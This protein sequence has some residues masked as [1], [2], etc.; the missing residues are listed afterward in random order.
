VAMVLLAFAADW[1][2]GRA[3]RD[4]SRTARR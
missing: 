3:E 4:E 2:V 1:F